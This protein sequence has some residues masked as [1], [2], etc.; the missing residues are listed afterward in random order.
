MI[1]GA[2][3]PQLE[4]GAKKTWFL[5]KDA[6]VETLQST[7]QL[8]HMLSYMEVVKRGMH[9]MTGVPEQALGQVQPI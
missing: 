1:T 2:K 3:V 6:R 4:K 9:E 5:P 7:W 8:E